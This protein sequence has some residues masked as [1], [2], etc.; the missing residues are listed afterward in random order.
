[1]PIRLLRAAL[2]VGTVAV[3]VGGLWR[4]MR[5]EADVRHENNR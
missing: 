5:H 2:S 3:L 4:E 1:M